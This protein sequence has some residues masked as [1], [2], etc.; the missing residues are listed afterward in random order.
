M[1]SVRILNIINRSS[2]VNEYTALSLFRFEEM[3]RHVV[4]IS[5]NSES[6]TWSIYEVHTFW[7]LT[8]IMQLCVKMHP[9]VNSCYIRVGGL[10]QFAQHT[11]ATSFDYRFLMLEMETLDLNNCQ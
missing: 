9:S 4:N 3:L 11:L 5:E 10:H 6:L 1:S 7:S 2:F 8:Q